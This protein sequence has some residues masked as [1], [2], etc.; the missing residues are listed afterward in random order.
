MTQVNINELTEQ[1]QAILKLVKTFP[2]KIASIV[3]EKDDLSDCISLEQFGK[4]LKE[5][6]KKRVAAKRVNKL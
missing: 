5:E 2:K 6:V 1:G 3:D 4:K